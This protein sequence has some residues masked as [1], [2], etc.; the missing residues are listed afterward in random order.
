M[1]SNNFLQIFRIF[2]IQL[3]CREC[4][5]FQM[6][7]MDQ[8]IINSIST[9]A[10]QSF[11]ILNTIDLDY[12]S[13]TQTNIIRIKYK[14]ANCKSAMSVFHSLVVMKNKKWNLN[15]LN[16]CSN[17]HKTNEFET[18][19]RW[20]DDEQKTIR[21]NCNKPMAIRLFEYRTIDKW[22][23]KP[24]AIKKSRECF[25]WITKR[26]NLLKIWVFMMTARVGIRII[27][28]LLSLFQMTHWFIFNGSERKG[29]KNGKTKGHIVK[30]SY[31]LICI[32]NWNVRSS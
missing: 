5:W 20:D 16:S 4:V 15:K 21:E 6:L 1:K 14:S 28:P 22:V 11:W 13:E 9:Q 25:D 24:F 26:I 32:V 12:K 10:D 3:E 8:M 7:A 18:N 17:I 23:W 19:T 2:I 30:A 31:S 27:W 29:K